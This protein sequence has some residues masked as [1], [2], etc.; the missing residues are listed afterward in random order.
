MTVWYIY[1][2]ECYLVVKKNEIVT[3]TDKQVDLETV[4][5]S[6]LTQTHKDKY[7]IFSHLWLLKIQR[8]HSQIREN[9]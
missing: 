9:M 7:H 1:T 3:F 2:M 4:I 8:Y 6:E 5:L